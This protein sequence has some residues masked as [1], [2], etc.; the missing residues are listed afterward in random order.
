MKLKFDVTGMTCAA[1]SARVEKV[2]AAV[3]GVEKV[4]VNLL[5]GKMTVEAASDVS[6]AIEKAV[7]DAGYGIGKPAEKKNAAAPAEQS[8]REMKIRII[9][10]AIFL[11]ILMYFTMGHMVSQPVP[12][13]YH[14]NGMIAALLQFFLTL[15]VVYLNRAYYI[16]GF[17]ALFNRGPNMDSLIAVGSSAALVYGVA[18]LF[19]M[20]DAMGAGDMER[21]A[22]YAGNL[23]FKKAKNLEEQKNCLS[24]HQCFAQDH[25]INSNQSPGIG[26]ENE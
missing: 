21:V 13:W 6:A 3:A 5:A 22:H 23:Y 1:C 17:K 24:A 12:N 25:R 10:S 14:H 19:L 11:V 7:V 8:L 16:K 4:E 9:G 15:P 2:T 18:V 20:A 26:T